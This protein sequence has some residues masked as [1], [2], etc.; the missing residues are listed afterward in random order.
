MAVFSEI[1]DE[2]LKEVI[3][4]D[5][6]TML[7]GFLNQTIRETNVGVVSSEPVFFSENRK[8][9]RVTVPS[10]TDNVYLWPIPRTTV[11]QAMD[12]V[13][14]EKYQV[15]A[16]LVSPQ[17]MRMLNSMRPNDVFQYYRS[18]PFYAMRGFGGVGDKIMLAWYEYPHSLKYY[19]KGLTRP[20]TFD[21]ETQTYVQ[22]QGASISLAAAMDLSTNWIL[23]RHEEML[24]EGLRAKAY[25]RMDQESRAS[26]AYSKYKQLLLGMQT[27]ESDQLG[28]Y[29][30]R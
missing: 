3:R 8:E 4:P 19:P 23:D 9:D 29:H 7:P 26:I 27:T 10:V 2:V 5:L 18:G 13:F 21:I 14:F 30:H 6:I 11:F 17:S 28:V 15:Y 25:A 20:L 16:N 24:K 22:P 1:V 12:A